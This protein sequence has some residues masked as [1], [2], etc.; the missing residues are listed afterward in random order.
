M[1]ARP[2]LTDLQ[3][4]QLR[5]AVKLLTAGELVAFPT[6]TVYGLGA[7]ATNAQAVRKIFLAKGRP[8]NNPLIVHI[9]SIA[10]ARRYAAHWPD[11]AQQLA[12][13]FWPGPLTLVLGKNP[14]I[15]D[16]ATAG[17][18]T[19]GLRCPDHP[20]TLK[21]LEMFDRPL[22]GPSAN[23]SNH[24]SPTTAEHVRSDLA[25]SVR[26]VLDGGPCTVGIESTVL[27]LAGLVPKILRPGEISQARLQ[28]CIGAAV[29]YSPLI[30]AATENQP[31]EGPGMLPK[32]YAPTTPAYRFSF[33]EDTPLLVRWLKRSG[34]QH[35]AMLASFSCPAEIRTLLG[36][37]HQ[38]HT[39]SADAKEYA[40]ALYDML[41]KMDQLALAAIWIEWPRVAGWEAIGDRLLRA[42][43]PPRQAFDDG[44]GAS[45]D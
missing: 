40:R 26:L 14:V 38:W 19:V 34:P 17:G 36:D 2:P 28:E 23:R 6:E 10:H 18:T 25:E 33:P 12:E 37:H 30:V 16:E 24:I 5:Q 4:G 7:D 32:H 41:R 3:Q 20:L 1:N 43:R 11:A 29:E 21:L 45:G 31:L 22:A 8:S 13:R 9:G 42:T 44:G 27:S 15:V 35:A 39:M